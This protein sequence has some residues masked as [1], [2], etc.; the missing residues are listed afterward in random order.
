MTF[1]AI[2]LLG[3][4]GPEGPAE[5]RPFL[6]RVAA[7]RGIPV[8]RLDEVEQ[9]YLA[10]GG[11]SPI[12]AQNR[13]LRD[14]LALALAELGRPLPVVLANR[15]SPPFV[16]DA[17]A[18]LAQPVTG[19]VR[20]EHSEPHTPEERGASVRVLA[21]ATSAYASYSSCRQYREDVGVALAGR[22]ELDVEVV[23]LPPFAGASGLAE[24]TADLLAPALAEP[25]RR[26][27]V[28]FTTHSLPV[29]MARISGPESGWPDAESG[30]PGAYVA[31]H[32]AVA[33]EALTRASAL[34][35]VEVPPWRLVF[36]SRS[37]PPSVPWLE[38]DI[39]DAL[40]ELAA[41]GVGD[42]VVV[43]IGFL[44][45]HVEVVWDL[46]TAAAETARRLGLRFT[47]VPTVGT[48]PAFVAGLAEL[49]AELDAAATRP[50]RPGE[51][52]WGDCCRA[53]RRPGLSAEQSARPVIEGVYP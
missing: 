24:A 8:E 42:V 41:E 52:C 1:D 32:L 20:A 19:D 4:G 5:V 50:P 6:E 33:E 10:L 13:A 35:G 9:R 30:T 7:G 51:A 43:P 15:N 26:P 37:G 21:V 46:D 48:H 47:R 22:P 45:D 11:V 23:K 29:A 38:P 3:F 17:L 44:S 39:S 31:Q 2:L 36:Q 28:L 18:G 14:A 49:I 53:P 27:H 12:N 40:E 25:G 16:G 34:A